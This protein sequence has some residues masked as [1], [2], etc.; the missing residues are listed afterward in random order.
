M[1]TSNVSNEVSTPTP[2][3]RAPRKKAAST[4][5]TTPKRTRAKSTPKVSSENKV[6]RVNK[7]ENISMDLPSNPFV[8]EVLMLA[9]QFSS[10][11]KKIEVLKKYEHPSLKTIFIWNFDN[12]V[13]SMLPP[14]EVPYSTVG[15][16]LVKTGT[17]SDSIKKEVEQ[18]EAHKNTSIAYTDKIRAEHTSLRNEYEK[19][20]NFVMSRSGMPGNANLSSL[21]RESMFIEMVK[22]LHPLDAEIIC[23]VKD[24]KLQTKYDLTRELISA[25][26]PDITWELHR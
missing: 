10:T 4:T 23:L 18:M 22:G 13:L 25:A 6:V 7:Q 17:V 5:P 2:K 14:G 12:N 15:E 26:Y 21:R 19:L 24:K 8:F 3:P 1:T 20:I 16:D 9:E 11:E